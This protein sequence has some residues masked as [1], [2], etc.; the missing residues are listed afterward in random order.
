MLTVIYLSIIFTSMMLKKE[1]TDWLFLGIGFCGTLLGEYFFVSTGV[2]TF[3]RVSLLG[4]MP[5]WLPFLWGYI[6][7]A[8]K[9]VFWM[10]AKDY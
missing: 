6:F 5:V 10:L 2:E 8:M 7:L 1:R 4:V 3:H 9:R